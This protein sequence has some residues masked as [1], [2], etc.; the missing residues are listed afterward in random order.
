[1]KS[2][3]LLTL[4]VS[5]PA[6]AAPST[7]RS[8]DYIIVGGGTAGLTVANRLT[9][10]PAITVAVIEAGSF[11]ENV[12]GNLSQVPAYAF[13]IQSA[14]AT[15]P[16]LGWGFHTTPQPGLGGAVVDYV[17][18]KTLGGCSSIN[19]VAY[20]R[21]SK[22]AFKLWAD[23]VGD[24]SYTWDR[25]LPYYRK[26]MDFTPPDASTRFANASPSY[27]AAATA[28]GGPLDITY[29]AYAESWS[30]W[31]ARGLAAIGI[32]PTSALI[33]GTL[34]GS[35]WQLYTVDHATGHRASSDTAFLRPSLHRPNLVVFTE[36]LAERVLFNVWKVAT[37]VEATTTGSNTTFT[38]TARREVI[39][40][41][42]VFQSPQLLMVSG[43]GPRA[44]L[45]QYNIPVVADRPGVGQGM[46]DHILIP[47]T[48]QVNL[49]S[50][51]LTSA[52][53]VAEFNTQARGPLTNP[54]G[55][56]VGLEKIPAAFRTNWSSEK[57]TMLAALPDDWPEIEYLVL[58]APLTGGTTP[59]ASYATVFAALQA[60]QSTGNVSIAS[61]SMGDPPVINPNWLTAQADLDV[62]LAA[63]KRMRQMAA[64]DAMAD[65]IIGEEFLPGPAVQTDEQI[66]AYFRL[67]GTSISHAHATNPMGKAS[68]PKAVVGTTGKVY[69]VK[70]LRVIDA[71]VFPFLL[72]GPAPQSHVYMLAEKLADAIKKG[73]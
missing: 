34:T 18:A 8:F 51:D 61:A 1:M 29:A 73:Y 5:A 57:K 9:E 6:W 38:L 7:L 2:K 52:T 12:V 33:D 3:L 36:T 23:T 66:L 24:Q 62:L 28:R 26:S 54:G 31:V 68:D 48:Y 43:V 15:N 20:S 16:A 46:R 69:G 71:S 11:V 21:S 22:G 4:C 70:S 59:G 30:T 47:L 44:V 19:N 49:A 58:P 65:V 25:V 63:F 42:G 55:D 64:S 37:G 10:N 39:L 41:A 13:A 50:V 56:F 35:T 53:A 32:P 60:P 17:R 45:Q 67:A 40:S 72:P 27:N 14:A